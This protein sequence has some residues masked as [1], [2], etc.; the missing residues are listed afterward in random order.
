MVKMDFSFSFSMQVTVS[1]KS[2]YRLC[3]TSDQ[4]FRCSITESLD[5]I[6]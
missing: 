2:V 5:T 3:V 6:E 1:E 4:S